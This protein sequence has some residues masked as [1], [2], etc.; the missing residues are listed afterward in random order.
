MN[1]RNLIKSRSLR[2]KIL[3]YFE[4]IPDCLML[5]FQYWLQTGRWLN[6]KNPKRFTEKLQLYKI[7]Y[8]NGNML[9]CTDKYEVR[10]YLQEKGLDE[11]LIPLIG[12]FNKVSDID[13]EKLPKQ[14]VAK[15]TD[16]G[17]GNNV[18][19][20]KD[21]NK[22]SEQFFYN[23]LNNWMET[24]KTKSPGREWAYENGYPRRIIIEELLGKNI[25]YDLIDYKFFCFNGKVEYIYCITDR[26]VGVSAQFGIYDVDF[27]KLNICRCDERPQ[28][29]AVPKPDNY[30]KMIRLS[31]ILS[32]EFPHVRV[33]LYNVDGK[34]FF[35]ELTFYD[36]SGYMKFNPDSFDFELGSKFDVSLFNKNINVKKS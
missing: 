3:T 25:Q 16:G 36:G 1:Y 9:R 33:D 8:R 14:F 10:K 22:I 11:Y 27:N 24:P 35:G 6:L 26:Q 12:I 5:R 4:F 32:K 23:K 17:G 18:F 34:I 7:K 13:F 20:C 2:I 15:T 30:D 31:E 21:K 29:V 28:T 19:I